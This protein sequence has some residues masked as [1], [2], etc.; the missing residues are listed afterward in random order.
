MGAPSSR[1]IVIGC[2]VSGIT[3]PDALALDTL[4][5]LQ[6]VARRF[7][8]TIRLYNASDVLAALIE[9]AGLAEVL[10]VETS[11]V[12]VGGQVEEGEELGVDEEV[13][14]RDRAV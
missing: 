4:A 13:H 6:L 7:G 5:R 12:E 11:V 3:E 9:C 8:A 10:E 2:D 1:R 14:G